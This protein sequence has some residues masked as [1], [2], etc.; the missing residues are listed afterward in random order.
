MSLLIVGLDNT[1][2]NVA[3]PSIQHDLHATV[4]G[5][6]WTIDAYTLVLASL[7][8]LS[9][10]TADRFGRRRMFSDRPRAVHARFAA[11]QHG[12]R[13][14][15]AHRVPD[16]PGGRRLDAQPG[17]DVDHHER[18]HRPARTRPG[19][20]RVGR[21]RRHQPALGPVVGG[22]LVDSVGWRSIFWINVPIGLVALALTLR[23]VPES[24]PRS[25]DALDPVGQA[26]GP[27]APGSLTFGIIEGP[28]RGW[29][30]PLIIACFAVS[31]A[32]LVGFIAYEP[33]RRGA[34]DRPAVLPQRPVRRRHVI[35]VCAF[36]ALAAFLFLNTLYLQNVRGS[37]PLPGRS[38]HAAVRRDDG[39]LGRSPGGSSAAG[40][41]GSRW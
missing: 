29:G 3:L 7:L 33:R 31:A 2:V 14:R 23:F 13:T 10:S 32:A 5:L 35:A 12:A 20:R 19:D 8:M 36:A 11:V 27:R 37:Q 18:V 38:R 17:R 6:Q 4:S 15:L 1:I 9:G 40:A 26:A 34:A 41:P 30:S 22:A 28:G 25:P 21:R 39:R 24:R 16:G